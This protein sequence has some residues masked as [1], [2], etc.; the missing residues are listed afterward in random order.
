AKRSWSEQVKLLEIVLRSC[1]AEELADGAVQ[2][3]R[4]WRE[5]GH[6]ADDIPR[7]VLT[8]FDEIA[9]SPYTNFVDKTIRFLC[10][11]EEQG[12]LRAE[13]HADLVNS[14]LRRIGRHLT[15]FDLVT[16]HHRGA[17]YPDALLLDALLKAYLVIA[18]R[19]SDLFLAATNDA[20]QEARAK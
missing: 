5:I 1:S 19:R 13:E 6:A 20:T 7:L 18:E 14:L 2:F 17:N 12:A 8:M 16:F 15:A 9:L 3:A 4:R 11:L 10:L